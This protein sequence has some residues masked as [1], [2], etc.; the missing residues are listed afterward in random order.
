MN[1][2]KTKALEII[3]KIRDQALQELTKK[4]NKIDFDHAQ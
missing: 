2:D 3:I 1:D 4:L